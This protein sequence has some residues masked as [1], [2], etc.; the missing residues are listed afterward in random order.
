M[1][2][3][4][5]NKKGGWADKWIYGQTDRLE[6]DRV[7]SSWINKHSNAGRELEKEIRHKN[8]KMGR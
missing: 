1:R 6:T 3:G 8:R 5:S 7:M 2:F 4:N